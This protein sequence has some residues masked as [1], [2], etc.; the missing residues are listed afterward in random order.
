M[1][2]GIISLYFILYIYIFFALMLFFAT[3]HALFKKN[4]LKFYF[5]FILLASIFS[6]LTIRIIYSFYIDWHKYFE[7]DNFVEMILLSSFILYFEIIISI[8]IYFAIKK[9][10]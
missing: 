2:K 10:N 6:I 3:I 7:G 9:K 8:I 1:A 5:T 4:I